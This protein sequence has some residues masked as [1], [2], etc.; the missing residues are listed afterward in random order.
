[1]N[2]EN[3]IFQ[4]SGFAG[5]AALSPADV[6]LIRRGVF[7]NGIDSRVA[8]ATLLALDLNRVEK[9]PEW[10]AFFTRILS[11]HVV[12][13]LHPAGALSSVNIRWLRLVL[14]DGGVV[15]SRNGFETIIRVLELVGAQGWVLATMALD[16][17]W[18]AVV[19]GEGPLAAR[20]KGLHAV[21]RMDQ[22]AA[23]N[24]ILAAIG[25]TRRLSMSRA[26][27]L[28]DPARGG[29]LKER[30]APWHEFT[31]DASLD[32]LPAAA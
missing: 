9:C 32:A 4:V 24:R 17:I 10:D 22:F 14:F 31:F 18:L 8:L 3:Q 11:D 23:V 13:R 6:G 29:S 26:E 30:M 21:P 1:M 25:S 27:K 5:K 7:E 16:Q 2:D 12:N 28:F 20:H 19:E 15:V